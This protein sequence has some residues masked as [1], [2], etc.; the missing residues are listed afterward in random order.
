MSNERQ[1]TIED[2][3]AD[4]RRQNPEV[5]LTSPWCYQPQLNKMRLYADRIEAAAKR[6]R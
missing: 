3:V 6:E 5:F 4:I 2:I 1:E